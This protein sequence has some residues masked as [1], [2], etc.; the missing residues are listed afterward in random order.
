M[1]DTTLFQDFQTRLKDASNLIGASTL[2]T[3]V[4]LL[5]HG[6]KHV[7]VIKPKDALSN[8]ELFER[9]RNKK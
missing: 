9:I 6:A 5:V 3:I 2:C 1:S 7:T 8:D 4:R